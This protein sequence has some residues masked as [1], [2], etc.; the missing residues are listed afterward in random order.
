M[1]TSH[2]LIAKREGPR[3]VFEDRYSPNMNIVRAKRYSSERNMTLG[4]TE[5]HLWVFVDQ[6]NA[7]DALRFKEDL[8]SD[9]RLKASLYRYRRDRDRFI[10]SRGLLRRTLSLYAKKAPKKIRFGRSVLGEPFLMQAPREQQIKFNLSHSH[11]ATVIIVWANDWRAGVDIEYVRQDLDYCTIAE[12]MFSERERQEFLSLPKAVRPEAFLN[13]WTRKEGFVKALGQG[14]NYPVKNVCVTLKPCDHPAILDILDKNEK[15]ANWT[16][17]EI[18]TGKEYKA[19]IV[20]KAT[21]DVRELGS[22][23]R[24]IV[25]R[26][27]DQAYPRPLN[28]VK[29]AP[30][31]GFSAENQ[32]S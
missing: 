29:L 25:Y 26:E 3:I 28:G 12:E 17:V 19:H 30:T 13:C 32:I 24:I 15:A 6:R 2:G 27:W 16:V 21:A 7:M 23:V 14:F 9:E 4:K 20:F 5:L 31:D 8:S 11:L 22:P 18:K 1:S 10:I